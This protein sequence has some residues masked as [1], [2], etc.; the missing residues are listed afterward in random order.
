MHPLT[1]S[2]AAALHE[3]CGD[4]V[5]LADGALRS[6]ICSHRQ[7]TDYY[8]WPKRTCTEKCNSDCWEHVYT[9]VW[10][11]GMQQRMKQQQCKC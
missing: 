3:L 1:S 11:A 2:A 4:F 10:V 8:F 5:A 6:S 7:K 9:E